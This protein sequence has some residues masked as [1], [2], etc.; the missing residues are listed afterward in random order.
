MDHATAVLKT[1]EHFAHIAEGCINDVKSGLVV[2]PSHTDQTR[3]FNDQYDSAMRALLGEYDHT[4]TFQQ[5]VD[6]LKTGE[7]KPLLP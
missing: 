6:F 2:L 4:F 7:I 1:R 5:Y 3:Y